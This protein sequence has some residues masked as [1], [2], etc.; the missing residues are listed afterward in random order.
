[1]IL[2]SSKKGAAGKKTALTS[3]TQV[4]DRN[5]PALTPSNRRDERHPVA[6]AYFVVQI[7]MHMVAHNHAHLLR[8]QPYKVTQR[9]KRGAWRNFHE[10]GFA[11]PDLRP[12]A[13]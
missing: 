1:M 12:M 6:I 5:S 9:L 7:S 10:P 2:N 8:R 4:F 3:R 13:A 11:Q